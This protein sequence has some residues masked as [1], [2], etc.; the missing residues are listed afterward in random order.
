MARAYARGF[1]TSTPAVARLGVAVLD[2]G[3]AGR[4]SIASRTGSD[5]G[6]AVVWPVIRCDGTTP[7]GARGHSLP[8]PEA[9]S[10]KPSIVRLIA[11]GSFFLLTL[12]PLVSWREYCRPRQQSPRPLGQ[13]APYSR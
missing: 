1:A 11:L 10:R 12:K 8:L 7:T 13:P 3:G 6:A 5:S 2:I 4:A 9:A